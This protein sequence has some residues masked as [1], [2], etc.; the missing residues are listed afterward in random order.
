MILRK[1][2]AVIWDL[3]GV[4]IDSEKLHI[5]AEIE[6]FQ[7]YGINI[8]KEVANEYLGVKLEDYFSDVIKR[9]GNGL[10]DMLKVQGLKENIGLHRIS[11]AM[12][13]HTFT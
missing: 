7:K 10:T 6:T 9:F 1:I 11:Y 13:L 2:K 5:N 3:D 12:L 8:T 4:L